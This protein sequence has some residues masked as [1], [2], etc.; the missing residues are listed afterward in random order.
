MIPITKKGYDKLMNKLAECKKE[1]EKLPAIIAK[2]RAKGDL[3]ENAEYHAAREK[4]GM[5][6]AQ[7]G[8]INSD[9]QNS[10]MIDPK[11][12]PADLVNF[13]KRITLLN[14]DKNQ[15]EVYILMG[16]NESEDYENGLSITSAL[17]K[18]LMGKTLEEKVSITL[19]QMTKNY[20]IKKIEFNQF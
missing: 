6:N 7:I 14:L 16:P 4:Q 13:G 10:K 19:P 18:S 15:E 1:A 17:A 2:A 3:K 20:L 9:L 11:N 5:I 8:K 12:L